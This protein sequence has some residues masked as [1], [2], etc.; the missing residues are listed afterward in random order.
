MS[1]DHDH[2]HEEESQLSMEL[3]NEV[4]NLAN[5]RLEG[6][7]SPLLIAMGLRHAAANFSA[8]VYHQSGGGGDEAL[9][10]IVG[11][12]LRAFEYYLDRH[13]PNPAGPEGGLNDLIEQAKRQI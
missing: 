10:E 8:F 6:R 3:A 9:S 7:M 11:D 2:D 13:D 1:E 5:S 4:I 12:F